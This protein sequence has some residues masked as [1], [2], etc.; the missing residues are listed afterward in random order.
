MGW[1]SLLTILALLGAVGL[2]D[3]VTLS[4]GTVVRGKIVLAKQ[5]GPIFVQLANRGMKVLQRDQVAEVQ[6]DEGPRTYIRM[7]RYSARW[8]RLEVLTR[9]FAGPDGKRVA[10]V[11]AVHIGD[12]RYY[13]RM[14][15][16]LDRHDAVLFEGVG[17]EHPGDLSRATIPAPEAR[18][19]ELAALPPRELPEGLEL[20]GGL[21]ALSLLQ[22][23]MAETLELGFQRDEVDYRR[24][25]WF[26][27]DVNLEE[28][29]KLF[30]DGPA[31]A[32]VENMAAESLNPRRQAAMNKLVARTL[33]AA[34]KGLFGPKPLQLVLKE[35]CAE[36]L[37]SQFAQEPGADPDTEEHSA[38]DT[39]LIVER[40][41]VVIERLEAMLQN[42]AARTIAI[43]YGAGHNPDLEQRLV[44]L[45][46]SPV[47]DEWVPAWTMEVPAEGE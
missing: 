3:E 4:D 42:P 39:A 17:A 29:A 41:K 25:W 8:S 33:A 5:D 2:G 44:G 18:A 14:Q 16:I 7:C 47:A 43:F 13:G 6:R 31:A 19:Q 23:S 1:R 36:L 15:T 37:A 24:S 10:L 35:A 27:A 30:P 28:L 32:I 26:A 21:D 34:A 12:P 46:Y 38:F 11:G 9:T 22:T 45:G 40:N 20:E